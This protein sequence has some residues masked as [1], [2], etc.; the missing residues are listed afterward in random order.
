MLSLTAA[1][2]TEKIAIS[3]HSGASRLPAGL[4]REFTAGLV[5]GQSCSPPASA[6]CIAAN[7][8]RRRLPGRC[9]ASSDLSQTANDSPDPFGRATSEAGSPVQH[10]PQTIPGDWR[11][12]SKPIKPGGVYPAKELCSQCGLCDT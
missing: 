1:C 6:R 2:G 11:A 4:N 10:A 5:S 3:D 12:K 9:R 7:V 8:T